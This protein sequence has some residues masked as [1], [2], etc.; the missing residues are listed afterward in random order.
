[1][2]VLKQ[3]IR[4][5]K[6]L[7]MAAVLFTFLSVMFNLCWNR[8]LAQLLDGLEN[9]AFFGSEHEMNAFLAIGIIIILIHTMSEYVSSY[10][11]ACTCEIFAHEMRLGYARHF[12]QSDIQALS[13]LNVGE[14]QSAVQNELK[15]IS[16]YMSENLFSLI[17][18]LCTFVVTVVFLLCQNVKLAMISIVPVL[19]L[20]FYC[21]YSSK[22]IKDYTQKCQSSRKNQRAGGRDS[23]IVSGD[24]N[25]WRVW[26]D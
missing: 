3:L 25:L 17:K 10:L 5:H 9:T 21:F 1:M 13:K 26:A 14:E 4:L 12:L 2:N 15:E 20:I 7:F 24:S 18:Q 19:P 22:I 8:F 23:G 11:S 6:I 16:D